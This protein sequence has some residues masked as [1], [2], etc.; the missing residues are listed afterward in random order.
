MT[1]QLIKPRM[2]SNIVHTPSSGVFEQNVIEVV[3]AYTL[4]QELLNKYYLPTLD[5]GYIY[6]ENH[7]HWTTQQLDKSR[8]DND[9]YYT[10]EVFMSEVKE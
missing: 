10:T 2:W 4:T 9:H 6:I 5:G 3:G 8:K 1:D 7:H